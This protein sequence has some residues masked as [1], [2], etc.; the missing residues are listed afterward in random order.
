MVR[1]YTNVRDCSL[2]AWSIQSSLFGATSSL[3]LSV[4]LR[5][6]AARVTEDKERAAEGQSNVQEPNESQHEW[7]LCASLEPFESWRL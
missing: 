3:Y 4:S 7:R 2:N 5:E 6:S 1:V